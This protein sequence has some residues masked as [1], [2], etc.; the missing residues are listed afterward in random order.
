ML[1]VGIEVAGKLLYFCSVT[2]DKMFIFQGALSNKFSYNT[3]LSFLLKNYSIFMSILWSVFTETFLP[4][5]NY[6][7]SVRLIVKKKSK[8]S[9]SNALVLDR[10][11]AFF[12]ELQGGNLCKSM[13]ELY[14]NN[15]R[16]KSLYT[17]LIHRVCSC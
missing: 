10:Y 3:D 9:L 11:T 16:I 15:I 8:T 12:A 5:I 1:P 6:F 2:E 13:L 4:K 17:T 14:R 7:I